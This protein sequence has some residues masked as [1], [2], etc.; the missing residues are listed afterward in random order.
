MANS[1]SEQAAQ[2]GVYVLSFALCGYI[3]VHMKTVAK[4]W[5]LW[6]YFIKLWNSV[7]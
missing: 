4:S 2:R 5:C 1:S 6:T 3:D 7:Y